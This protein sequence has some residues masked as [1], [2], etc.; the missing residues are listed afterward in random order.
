MKTRS[1][2]KITLAL[3]VVAFMTSCVEDDPVPSTPSTGQIVFWSDFAGSP[4]SVSVGNLASGTIRCVLTSPPDCGEN[5]QC[6]TMTFAPGT[7]SY[8]AQDGTYTW[9][10]SFTITGGGCRSLNLT[11]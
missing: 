6:L 2:L 8:S 9:S 3:M 10:G 7:Y 11:I 5:S 4:I 1:F